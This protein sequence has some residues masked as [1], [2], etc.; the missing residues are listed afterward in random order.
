MAI[1]GLYLSYKGV[2]KVIKTI[3]FA[4]ISVLLLH[5][6]FSL[7]LAWADLV[8]PVDIIM[9][10]SDPEFQLV[11]NNFWY[12]R[13]NPPWSSY[14]SNFRFNY[15]GN[16]EDQAIYTYEIPSSG[17]YEVYAWWV[18]HSVCSQNT[19]YFIP[20]TD[21]TVTIR[22]N[23]RINPGQWNF[24]AKGFF[25]QGQY[26]IIISDDANGIVVVADAVRV[27]SANSA[28]VLDPIGDTS[29]YEGELLAFTVSASDA[30]GDGLTFTA[31]NL[32]PGAVFDPATQVFSWT[33]AAGQNGV[34]TNVS[35][36]VTDDGFIP[37]SDSED[38]TMTV[39]ANSAPVL[40]PIGDTSA[41]EG[42]LF[43][44]TVS[45][46]DADGDSLSFSAD[47]LPPEA[48][49]DPA[50]QVFSWTP[51][52][53]QNGVYTNISFTVTDDG[54][55][56]RSDSE[57]ITITVSANSAP[58]LDPIGDTSAYE[59]ELLEFTVSA[60][61]A[62]GH[63]LAFTADNLPPGAVFDPATQ[64]FSWTPAAGQ[65][66]VYTNVSFTVTDNGYIP[67]SDSEDITMTVSANSA[68]V[69]DPI[70]DTSVHEGELLE[71]T[72]SAS[73]ADGHNLTFTAD[74]LPPGAV[75]DPA[76][77][78]FSWTP[79][80]ESSGEHQGIVFQVSDGSDF[81]EEI[82]KLDII[83]TCPLDP[84]EGLVASNNGISIMLNW[85]PVSQSGLLA[86]YNVY[87]S[88]SDPGNYEKLNDLTVAITQFIDNDV[89]PETTYYYFVTAV[90]IFN[91]VELLSDGLSYPFDIAINN[92]G[93][94]FVSSWGEG[95][96]WNI[97]NDGSYSV[98]IAGSGIY[99]GLGFRNDDLFVTD[100]FGGNIFRVTPEKEVYPFAESFFF[101]EPGSP[102]FSADGELFL[103]E[104]TNGRIYRISYDGEEAEVF[105]EGLDSPGN[106][107]FD[108]AGNL[109]VGEDIWEGN[110]PAGVVNVIDADGNMILFANMTDPD[111][112]CFEKSGNLFVGQSHIDEV[113][114]VMPD[115]SSVPAIVLEQSPWGC[116]VNKFGELIVTLPWDGEIIKVHLSHETD[117]SDKVSMNSS[118]NSPVLDTIGDQT[119]KE[120]ELL[121]FTVTGSDPDGDNLTYSASN[122]PAGASFDQVTQVFSWTPDYLQ[123]GSYAVLFTVTDDYAPPLSDSED[124]TITV[125]SESIYDISISNAIDFLHTAQLSTG[126]FITFASSDITMQDD[127]YIDSAIFT[128]SLVL[129]SIDF[130]NDSRIHDMA[131]KG[132]DFLL[133][134]KIEPGLWRYYS[135]TNNKTIVPDIDDTACT[136]FSLKKHDIEIDNIQI[137]TDN[138]NSQGL[139]NTWYLN[140][141]Y[142]DPGKEPH[143]PAENDTDCVVNANALLYLGDRAETASVS[144]YLNNVIINDAEDSC[145]V[146]YPDKLALYYKMS[147]AYYEGVGTMG[148]SG[149]RII[150]K[151]LAMRESDGSFGDDLQTA[152]ALNTLL[153]Y[154]YRG[155]EVDEAVTKLLQGQSTDGSWGRYMFF[156][157]PAPYYGSAEL[158]T[159]FCIE[160]LA[161]FSLNQPP[162][163]DPIGNFTIDNGTTLIFTVTATD[164]EGNNMVFAAS[165]LPTGA[166]F[167][168]VTRVFSWTPDYDQDGNYAVLFTVTD[169]GSPSLSDS[170]EITI[171]A[172]DV[173]RPPVLVP[174]GNKTVNEGELLEFTVTGSDP[175][176]DNLTYSTSNLPS[177]AN[178]NPVT[179][180]FSWTPD[181]DQTGIYT[182]SFTVTDD[183]DPPLNYSEEVTLTVE[184]SP[185]VEIIIDNTDPEFSTVGNWYPY[186]GN[187]SYYESNFV[188]N[189]SGTGT[190]KAIFTPYVSI[191]GNYEVFAW[192]ETDPTGATNCPYTINHADGSSV[193]R[194]DLTDSTNNGRW[195]SLGIYQFIQGT[196]GTIIVS[197][198]ADGIYVVADAVRMVLLP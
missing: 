43:E 163:L 95:G 20:F 83:D 193:I 172:V 64:V 194:V 23:Q 198:D 105:V 7:S 175:D 115:G 54:D 77:Q 19:P 174:I 52:A 32:P 85:N 45:A 125:R 27:V 121:E 149:D 99:S 60:S 179:R 127:Y 90:D 192:L 24:L 16:G 89:M 110:T 103:I 178:F 40:D 173:N 12:N 87:R 176:G 137:I 74:N 98:Y 6:F 131:E 58:V 143:M 130:V 44:F 4:K 138:I 165:N 195:K 49:F 28:P 150:N 65:N 50:T 144:D 93:Q 170:E 69:L 111:G 166:N 51:A 15:S 73:D 21:G 168:P 102:I 94:L 72:V 161:K 55:Q 129:Y 123:A 63:N 66:G 104:D 68:P 197:D 162:R 42:E 152:L 107:T 46:S 184:S 139:F 135:S 78:V 126:E 109:F 38:M 186:T 82:I 79:D 120:G 171:T 96:I 1:V 177:G 76:T 181:Y 148:V 146:Y 36:T 81:D 37:L 154:G 33:P 157:G 53:G 48:V 117:I 75:F 3:T 116:I 142:L 156:L 13:N 29:A 71:F 141:E 196:S 31:D 101:E 92:K 134:E 167:N 9:D 30:D 18:S 62:D 86:G 164:W 113:T 155:N 91:H 145:S 26:Q 84:P 34:Y 57:D 80:W 35:F 124:I 70:G 153:N 39:S 11:G 14:G 97:N 169:D 61:D 22:V 67:L 17:Y 10:N 100:Y 151:V 132:I 47:N 122:L 119:V 190:D 180:V 189:V 160:A 25:E 114:R 59:G 187:H 112:V 8:L 182:I 136:S 185:P 118:N 158:T 5:T 183:G 191:S 41:Y 106:M 56:P 140:E 147:R 128:T 88:T 159:A 133:S 188:Y 2:M 108:N